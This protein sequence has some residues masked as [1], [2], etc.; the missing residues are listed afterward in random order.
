MWLGLASGRGRF[1]ETQRGQLGR[2]LRRQVRCKQRG[3]CGT[4][5]ARAARVCLGAAAL[6]GRR[7]VWGGA[8]AAS[9]SGRRRAAF[10]GAR[11]RVTPANRAC[12]R[13]AARV[14]RLLAALRGL[15]GRAGG[16]QCPSRQPRPRGRRSAVSPLAGERDACSARGAARRRAA[17]AA[18]PATGRSAAIRSTSTTAPARLCT[19]PRT[20]A[21]VAGCCGRA[22][23]RPPACP[24][25]RP[26]GRRPAGAAGAA[27]GRAGRGTRPRPLTRPLPSLSAF[28]EPQKRANSM[29]TV[30]PSRDIRFGTMP[31]NFWQWQ[32]IISG[33]SL[34]SCKF[35]PSDQGQQRFVRGYIF[36]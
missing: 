25:A 23:P 31:N 8:L 19:P 9:V 4:R 28:F 3:C 34:Q 15:R 12:A 29:V 20:P 16:A 35:R 7:G 26:S 30:H 6:R 32:T 2:P 17:R 13:R 21:A 1:H 27:A 10:W 5:C 36:R 14:R 18:G 33:G 11:L 24:G 22:R